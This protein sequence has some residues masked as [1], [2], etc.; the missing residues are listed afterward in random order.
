MTTV[1]GG[2]LSLKAALDLDWDDPRARTQGL[3]AVLSALD[4]LDQY[5]TLHPTTGDAVA[6]ASGQGVAPPH[7]R[8]ADAP[9]LPRVVII[10]AGNLHLIATYMDDA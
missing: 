10:L 8:S 3:V 6:D 2:P 7:R 9:P 5:L 1:V 4:T